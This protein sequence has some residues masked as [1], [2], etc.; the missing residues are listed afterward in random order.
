[1]HAVSHIYDS[2]KNM[3]VTTECPNRN[4]ADSLDLVYFYSQPLVRE[5]PK[6]E[7]PGQFD[8]EPFTDSLNFTD[9]FNELVN[10]LKMN[11]KEI[12]IMKTAV[13]FESLK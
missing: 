2:T 5:V 13:N 3:F 12:R 7:A 1:M 8:L 6:L 9:E 11:K 4:K 10:I